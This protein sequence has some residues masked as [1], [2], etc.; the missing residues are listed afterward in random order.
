MANDIFHGLRPGDRVML[1]YEQN[2]R[3]HYITKLIAGQAHGQ[4]PI[5][6]ITGRRGPILVS[7]LKKF[8][9]R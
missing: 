4:E 6:Y 1:A 5:A 7:E 8:E 2:H 9:Q 3:E